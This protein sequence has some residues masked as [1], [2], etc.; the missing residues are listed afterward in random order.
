[1]LRVPE[2]NAGLQVGSHQSGAERQ[3]HLPQLVAMFVLMQHR[4]GW[5]S[6][7]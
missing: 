5:P 7:L 1:V 3:N 2:L 4:I 6:G